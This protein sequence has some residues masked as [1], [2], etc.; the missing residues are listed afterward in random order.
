M[1]SVERYGFQNGQ[2]ST[3]NHEDRR[4]VGKSVQ[5]RSSDASHPCA[6]NGAGVSCATDGPSASVCAGNEPALVTHALG[7][8]GPE[9]VLCWLLAHSTLGWERE[10]IFVRRP[11]ERSV[12]RA[13]EPI[14]T[15]ARRW[16]FNSIRVGVQLG[17]RRG[18]THPK[19]TQPMGDLAGGRLTS[20]RQMSR[21]QGIDPT[22]RPGKWQRP[23]STDEALHESAS[24]AGS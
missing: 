14:P 16:G 12:L 5:R 19:Y 23:R 15:R 3:G 11:D 17:C 13:D 7:N 10:P 18:D 24:T 22:D 4:T 1:F 20:S 8:S 9:R 2:T 21:S 6:V